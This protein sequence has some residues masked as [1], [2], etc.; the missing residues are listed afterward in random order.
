M[1]SV[2]TAIVLLLCLAPPLLADSAKYGEVGTFE[3]TP[4]APTANYWF[5]TNP[6]DRLPGNADV[7]YADAAA[8]LNDEVRAKVD[9]ALA[10]YT[11]DPGKFDALATAVEQIKVYSSMQGTFDL[12]A[13][14]TRRDFYQ[15]DS[16]F[17]Q[18]GAETLL[19]HVVSARNLGKLIAVH[20]LRQIRA[21]KFDDAVNTLRLEFELGRRVGAE[22]IM[23]CGLVG[24]ADIGQAADVTGELMKERNCP[25]LYWAFAGMPHPMIT[26]PQALAGE[27]MDMR[28]TFPELATDRL[29]D[30]SAEQWHGIF[31]RVVEYLKDEPAQGVKA[32][33]DPHAVA[34]EVERDLP[35]ASK[36]YSDKFHVPADQVAAVDPFKVVAT[37]WY[38]DQ[39]AAH[40]QMFQMSALPYPLL[41]PRLKD[42]LAKKLQTQSKLPCD[43][44]LTWVA[45]LVPATERYMRMD[46]ELAALTDVEAIRSYAAANNGKLPAHLEEITDTPAL[47]NPRTG[48]PFDYRVDNDTATLSDSALAEHPLDYTIRI[49]H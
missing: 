45:S 40:A 37:W 49:R 13:I 6:I 27:V 34:D 7:L 16:S 14:A 47:D 46:R 29:A 30:V 35:E 41:A 44:F 39:Q 10:A 11:K 22:P 8:T 43:V 25:N 48:Q 19:P 5:L 12:L 33:E 21:G 18:Q 2:Y 24:V 31:N 3:L 23:I 4:S 15:W 38:C 26:L 1:K 9:A 42:F 36:F 28:V 32:W 20:A 17:R